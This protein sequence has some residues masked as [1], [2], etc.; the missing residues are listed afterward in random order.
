MMSLFKRIWSSL[1]ISTMILSTAFASS[2]SVCRELFATPEGLRALLANKIYPSYLEY[3]ETIDYLT[4]LMAKG[5]I[6]EF[7][8]PTHTEDALMYS[9]LFVEPNV[10]SQWNNGHFNPKQTRIFLPKSAS[11]IESFQGHYQLLTQLVRV[12]R[13]FELQE[14]GVLFEKNSILFNRPII[15]TGFKDQSEST[16]ITI[17]ALKYMFSSFG[18]KRI[19]FLPTDALWSHY[20]IPP[21]YTIASSSYSPSVVF[22]RAFYLERSD[23]W[24]E[25]PFKLE[26]LMFAPRGKPFFPS[27]ET[28][29]H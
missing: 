29:T 17:A 3:P 20:A 4:R 24:N 26:D 28:K 27:K 25:L 13:I 8:S 15:I 1:L 16:N 22:I 9:H 18:V 7:Y 19:E 6:V 10:N 23:Y 11:K 21:L 5:V 12:H 14:Q 2:G